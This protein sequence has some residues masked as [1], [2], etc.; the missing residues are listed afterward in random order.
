MRLALALCLI[1]SAAS[2]Y[3]AEETEETDTDVDAVPPKD[4]DSRPDDETILITGATPLLGLDENR[5]VTE[6]LR[7]DMELRLP[8]SAP[9]ALRF[10][11]GVFVQQTAHSQGSAFIRGLTGQQTLI[12]FDGIRLNNS[13]YRQG[14]NQYFFTLD[15]QTIESL[16]VERGGAS[17]RYGSD[18]LGGVILAVPIEPVLAGGG[19]ALVTWDPH[20]LMRAATADDELG[21]RFQTHLTLKDSLAFFGGVG[22][23]RVGLLESGG[24][25][26]NPD[27]S[28]TPL[29]PRMDDDGRTQLGTGFKEATADGALLYQIEPGHRLKLAAGL[30]R[31][32]DAPRTDQCPA[33][34]APYDECL[35]YDEQFRTLVYGVYGGKVNTALGSDLRVTAS[36]Q[37]QHERRSLSRPSSYVELTGRDDVNTLGFT[38]SARARELHPASW[39]ALAF[40]YGADTYHDWITSASWMSFTDIHYTEQLSRGQYVDGSTYTYGGAFVA[41]DLDLFDF[42]SWRSGGRFSWVAAR[43]PDVPEA[44]SFGVDKQWTPL[45]G[46]TGLEAR[47]TPW[48]SLLINLDRSFRAPNLDDLTSRQQTGPGFQFENPNLGPEIANTVE[49]GLRITDLGP[50]TLEVFA[51]EMFLEGAVMKKPMEADD[52]PPETTQCENSWSRFQLVNASDQS[53]IKGLEAHMAL[54]LPGNVFT[55]FTAAWT[56]G[57]GPNPGDPPSDPSV[58]F[59]ETVPL[60]RIPP[61]NGTVEALWRH[62]SGLSLGAGL[63]YAATQDRLAL[64]DISDERIPRGGTPGFAVL[65]LRASYRIPNRLLVSLQFENVFDTA[66]RYHGSSVNGPARGLSLLLDLG[67]LWRGRD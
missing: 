38:L 34:Y 2:V 57:E 21:G 30:Y 55:R 60:S 3:A 46:N 23:R 40:D 43:A 33:A 31:Q 49:A 39:L 7:E 59:D 15:S 1:L 54:A 47:A 8:R 17:T 44:G 64:A 37:N 42:L 63:R 50:V 26:Y 11:P 19:D 45:V 56:H 48:L 66:Y 16:Q 27:G 61:F 65:D 58:P 28:G 20:L 35:Q 4:A 14:P 67:P 24:P 22:G 51:Y 9:D 25:I 52:C 12:L 32:F 13:T 29:V 53:R 41:S 6:V 36:W 5:A 18:A 62:K 10:E